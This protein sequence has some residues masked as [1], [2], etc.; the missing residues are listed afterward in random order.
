MNGDSV[1]SLVRLF[2]IIP[3]NEAKAD[4][5]P[6]QCLKHGFVVIHEGK[7]ASISKAAFKIIDDAYG[8]DANKLNQTFFQN[9]G[10]VAGMSEFEY[11]LHQFM[12]YLSTYGAEELGIEMETYL[13]RDDIEYPEETAV[14]RQITII[15]TASDSEIIEKVTDYVRKTR[16]PSPIHVFLIEKIL[17][18]ADL[19]V[20]EIKSFEIQVLR[21][22]LDDTV[23]DDPTALL[24]YLVYKTT[25]TTLLIKNDELI[26]M[27]KNSSH[28]SNDMVA[29]I[30]NK[31]D[32]H[33]LASCFYRYKPLFLA[34]KT[35]KGCAPIINKIRRYAKKDHKPVPFLRLQNAV[36][37]GM[38]GDREN[39]EKIVSNAENRAL[40]KLYSA[41]G[42][43]TS[44]AVYQI[45]NGKTYVKDEAISSLFYPYEKDEIEAKQTA[46]KE[47]I[48]EE[49]KKRY[50]HL[51]GKT[52]IVPD[53][54]D[55]TVPWTEKQFVDVYPFG[56]RIK[57]PENTAFTA[58]IHW[59]N[60][61]DC[62][63]DLDL[64]LNSTSA[65][66]GWNGCVKDGLEVIFSGDMTDA[67]EPKG[68]AEAYY[69]NGEYDTFILSIHR[70]SGHGDIK[71]KFF[72]TNDNKEDVMDKEYTFYPEK[73]VFPPLPLTMGDGFGMTLGMFDKNSFYIYGGS[74]STRRVPVGNYEDYING[75]L[76]Q[77]KCKMMFSELFEMTGAVVV[78]D[79]SKIPEGT[80][81]ENITDLH[82]ET[83]TART[84]IGIVDAV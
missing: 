81:A 10:T 35:H 14:F 8:V 67:P 42:A 34:F 55:Y 32:L 84:L 24:R 82:P 76:H 23:P 38:K 68:A 13:P 63:V 64:H 74:V 41:L 77:G 71:F 21:Y 59:F 65:H 48:R 36:A 46:L 83:L 28:A 1:N 57:T 5:S 29:N 78:N 39:F 31:A 50:A 44:P 9:F 73:A 4:C 15:T 18:L 72:I 60:Q 40:F 75:L 16:S 54:I 66:F 47:I 26:N 53:Y 43:D 58:G 51:S 45:R 37:I 79:E 62:R 20:N 61:P 12:H 17:L 22:D 6:T 19:P 33:G 80:P 11:Y 3:E 56:T 30:L 70:Y 52:F 25:L 7:P 2:K 69:I 49:I 27:I